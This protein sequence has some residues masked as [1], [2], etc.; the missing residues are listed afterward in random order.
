LELEEAH[1]LKKNT[2]GTSEEVFIQTDIVCGSER[3]PLEWCINIM[4]GV[5]P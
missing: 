2:V 3:M 5:S 1:Y 4:F